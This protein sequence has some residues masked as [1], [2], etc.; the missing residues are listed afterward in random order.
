MINVHGQD[1]TGLVQAIKQTLSLALE[2]AVLATSQYKGL[3]ECACT[4]MRVR[5]R[6]H[7]CAYMCNI[8][9]CVCLFVYKHAHVY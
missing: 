8:I 5:V 3:C 1:V 2:L 6:A 7:T 9:L 4:C